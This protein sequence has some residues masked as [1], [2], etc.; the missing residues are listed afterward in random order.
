MFVGVVS[1]AEVDAIAAEMGMDEKRSGG[2]TEPSEESKASGEA[3]LGDKETKSEESTAAAK[4]G[5]MDSN[6]GGTNK[7]PATG[8]GKKSKK[9]KKKGDIE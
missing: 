3:E 8:G 6:S 5:G 7:T 9:K 2:D 1:D 4:D